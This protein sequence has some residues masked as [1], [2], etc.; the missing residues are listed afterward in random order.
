MEPTFRLADHANLDTLLDLVRAYY[1][2]DGH[3]Y[4]HDV[5]RAALEGLMRKPAFGRIW[6]ICDGRAP[7]GYVIL[8]IGYSIEYHGRDAFVDE[9]YLGESYR[10]RGW[11]RRALAFV[12]HACR[13]LG[14]HALH[15]EAERENTAAY[16]VYRKFGF[17]VMLTLACLSPRRWLPHDGGLFDQRKTDSKRRAGAD[18]A[19]DLHP[20]A[21][22]CHDLV[23]DI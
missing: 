17:E 19:V 6:L 23:D 18:G 16:A 7:I 20:A 9:L 13:G 11:G 22:Q 21:V 15:L 2:F 4:A 3:P 14:V 1:E 8:T 10:G 12:E 5:V